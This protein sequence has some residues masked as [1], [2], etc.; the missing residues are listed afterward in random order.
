MQKFSEIPYVRPD[1]AAYREAL[2]AY[3][4]QIRNAA[5]WPELKALWL[6]QSDKRLEVMTARSIASIRN[7][8]DTTDPFYEGEMR[9]FNTEMPAISLDRK[10]VV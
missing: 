3:V 4:E 5:S 8:V 6:A 2:P 10:S 9:Y 7:T 1:L